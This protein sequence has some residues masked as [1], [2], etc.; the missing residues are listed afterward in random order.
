MRC[1]LCDL[2]HRNT[3][4]HQSW[5][6]HQVCRACYSVLDI[7]SWNCNYLKEYWEINYVQ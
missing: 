5:I 6:E 7:F 1:K 2:S 3:S 4:R